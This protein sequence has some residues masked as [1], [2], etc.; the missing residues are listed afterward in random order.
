MKINKREFLKYT[1]IIGTGLIT[2][3]SMTSCTEGSGKKKITG[4]KKPGLIL[5]FKPYTLQ[6][7][8]SFN[9]AISSRTTT[10]AILTE[11]EWDGITGYGEASMPP[12]LGESIESVSK[13]LSSL[14]L[15]QFKNPLLIEDILDYVEH[16]APGNSAAKASVDIALHDLAGKILDEPI[17]TLLGL[18]P[19]K[20][21]DTSFTIGIDT[22]EIVKQKVLE[23][24]PYKILKVKLGGGN[25]REMIDTVR[26]MT[27]KPLCVDINQGWKDRN[28]ALEMAHWLNEKGVVFL[29]QPMPKEMVDDIAWLK[30]KSPIPVI[31]DEAIQNLSDLLKYKDV[32][33]GVNVKLMKCGGIRAAY[34]MLKTAR[35]L[36]LKTMIG[37]MTETSCAVTAAAHL[38]PLTYW[39]D[40]DG[41]LLISNDPFEGI[42]IVEGKVTLP[43]GA[44]IGI[45]K[46]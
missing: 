25:D 7:K 43:N 14:D 18:N 33:S 27:G 1:G 2:G 46:I 22:P 10:P 37:C 29:E 32:Y 4:N 45:R 16:S 26:E 15:Q 11:I 19:E 36:G 6:L 5:R 13:F 9:L 31:G 44:G 35:T 34:I 17:Y 20:A 40:L 21:P 28:Y 24:E 3:K 41:N 30:E 23:A 38:C 42:K 39:C 8:H 12:Y